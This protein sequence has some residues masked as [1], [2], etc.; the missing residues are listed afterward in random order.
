MLP[1]SVRRG[2]VS[3]GG[4]CKMIQFKLFCIAHY[5]KMQVCLRGLYSLYT[6]DIPDL[7]P[8]IGS[9]KTLPKNRKR[10]GEKSEELFRRATEEDPSPG[11]T[12]EYVSCDLTESSQSYNTFSENDRGYESLVVGGSVRSV[13]TKK[14]RGPVFQRLSP[15]T[16]PPLP[17]RRVVNVVIS[18]WTHTLSLAAALMC[19]TSSVSPFGFDFKDSPSLLLPPPPSNFF[20]FHPGKAIY[21]EIWGFHQPPPPPWLWEQRHRCR[22]RSSERG[23]P[24]VSDWKKAMNT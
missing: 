24:E 5:H 16:L 19:I 9:G 6:Y 22:A 1:S 2:H 20:F 21:L 11:W 15:G 13:L 10:T 18:A 4:R 14:Q 12:G 7:W 8:H 17:H 23:L 3:H